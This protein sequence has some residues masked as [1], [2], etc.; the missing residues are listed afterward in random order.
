MSDF[1]RVLIVSCVVLAGVIFMA[2]LVG[3]FELI[4]ECLRRLQ[5]DVR[6]AG[7]ALDEIERDLSEFKKK[8][9][10][11]EWAGEAWIG[12]DVAWG[13]ADFSGEAGWGEVAFDFVWVG[14]GSGAV[15]GFPAVEAFDVG[16]DR[17]DWA[18]G[19][20][21]AGEYLPGRV[22]RLMKK[23]SDTNQDEIL[24][25]AYLHLGAEVSWDLYG[26]QRLNPGEV[27][28]A[29]EED[30]EVDEV[31]GAACLMLILDLCLDRWAAEMSAVKVGERMCAVAAS[32]SHLGGMGLP[33]LGASARLERAGGVHEIRRILDWIFMGAPD[34][35]SL[36]K[37]VVTI[38]KFVS[39]PAFD[40]W[41]MSALGRACGETPQAMQERMEVL[42]EA[43]LRASGSKGKAVWQQGDRQRA[44]SSAA[45]R[46]FYEEKGGRISRL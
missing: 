36:G 26:R 16:G 38:G 41:S 28:E 9:G 33:M 46:R 5:K 12:W 30:A 17:G 6:E 27:L 11:D 3:K 37:R 40:E 45:Q 23:A 20:D 10:S 15:G 31:P 1:D 35:V 13:V 32:V 34:P 4:V 24:D 22:W 8:G 25:E 29:A 42:C 14:G 18:G 21:W 39:H 43:P 7:R 44:R 19:G 2:W